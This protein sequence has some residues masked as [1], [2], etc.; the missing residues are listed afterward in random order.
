MTQQQQTTQQNQKTHRWLIAYDIA[1]PKRLNRLWRTLRR[2]AMPIQRSVYLYSG[3]RTQLQRVLDTLE[4]IIDKKRDDLRAYPLG[5]NT[6]I[7]KLGQQHLP[8][9]NLLIDD[10]LDKMVEASPIAPKAEQYSNQ[11]LHTEQT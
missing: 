1:D 10:V 6:R 7:W 4:T 8:G 11:K 3:N 2:E 5:A 9:D